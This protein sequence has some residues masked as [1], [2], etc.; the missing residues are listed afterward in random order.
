MTCPILNLKNYFLFKGAM[1]RKRF[2]MLTVGGYV[3]LSLALIA[4]YIA[5]LTPA[6]YA[7]LKQYQ[8]AANQGTLPNG[9][10]F[11]DTLRFC[12]SLIILPAVV[13]R[14]R[15]C[16]W[17]AWW[18]FLLLPSI[19]LSFW[20]LV[21]NPLPLRDDAQ[22][23]IHALFYFVLFILVLKKSKPEPTKRTAQ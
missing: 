9:Y 8:D 5:S 1:G 18:A 15:D 22:A 4:L 6:E 16:G 23:F 7:A 13:L 12:L 14:L 17:R 10:G 2:I 20:R 11:A 19:G 21:E 3:G